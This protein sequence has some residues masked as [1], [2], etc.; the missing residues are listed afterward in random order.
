MNNKRSLL[1]IALMSSVL[2][3]TACGGDSDSGFSGVT[4]QAPIGNATN[5]P[6]D[7]NLSNL[8]QAKEM[9]RTAKLFVN[10][11]DAVADVYRDTTLFIGEND[12]NRLN[13]FLRFASD[14]QVY[15]KEQ[16][17]TRITG[18]D[19]N[20]ALASADVDE[21]NYVADPNLVATLSPE[22][23]F[24]LNGKVTITNNEIRH[25]WEP[26][27]G[28]YKEIVSSDTYPVSFSNFENNVTDQNT[29]KVTLSYGFDKITVGSGD[30]LTTLSASSDALKAQATFNKSV[31]FNDD[32][33]FE[34]AYKNGVKLLDAVITLSQVTLASAKGQLKA[35]DLEI[36][37]IDVTKTDA[38]GKLVSAS[39]VPYQ[40]KFNADL[41]NKAPQTDLKVTVNAKANKD[42]LQKYL[43]FDEYGYATEMADK[44]VPLTAL[45]SVKGNVTKE[46]GKVIPLDF[47]SQ[48]KR[49]AKNQVLLENLTA[50]VEGKTLYA[51]GESQLNADNEV[52]KTTI[53]FKQNKAYVTANFDENMEVITDKT[54]KINDIKVGDEDFGDLYDKGSMIEA[55]FT[56][57]TTI[58][59]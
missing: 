12:A 2:A 52:T 18:V 58:V 3:L 6:V 51:V 15:M 57:N 56:D 34:N 36:R 4:G 5:P 26:K 21:Y 19:I 10:D 9:V 35:H 20:K 55:K 29:N 33:E 1:S 22:G 53:T 11:A 59:L 31:N 37:V 50:Q 39:Q 14:L 28:L 13:G 25:G 27:R 54:G 23:K 7:V 40:I 16:R 47:Q 8:E 41:T 43:T 46:T 38:S 30:K 24:N 44:R 45:L 49:T 48:L 42:D 32:F 17:R